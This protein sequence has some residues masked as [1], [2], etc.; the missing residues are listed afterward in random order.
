MNDTDSLPQGKHVAMD[1]GSIYALGYNMAGRLKDFDEQSL[2]IGGKLQN[3]KLPENQGEV[4]PI[5]QDERWAHVQNAVK[6][7]S[8]AMN[9][10]HTLIDNFRNGMDRVSRLTRIIVNDVGGVD[11]QNKMTLKD[12]EEKTGLNEQNKYVADYTGNPGNIDDDATGLPP[13]QAP[14]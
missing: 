13:H 5:G 8:E 6:Y 9:G 2:H 3:Y 10:T 14:R 4:R 11:A 12:L 1:P 7:H